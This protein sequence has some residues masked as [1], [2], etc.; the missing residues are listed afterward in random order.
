MLVSSAKQA[1][2]V[3]RA[4]MNAI[5]IMAPLVVAFSLRLGQILALFPP[6]ILDTWNTPLV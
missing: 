6:G 2:P 5:D 1:G 4:M 3:L